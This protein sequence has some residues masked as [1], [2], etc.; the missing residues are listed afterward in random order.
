MTRGESAQD[1]MLC[2]HHT[3][4]LLC[5]HAEG[6]PAD[7]A[8]AARDRG[9]DAIGISDHNPM[10]RAFD[11]WRMSHDDLPRYLDLVEEARAAVDPFPVRLGLECDYLPGSESWIDT[12]ASRA[13]WDY[14][15]GA[16]HYIETDWDIDNPRWENRWRERDVGE[17]WG[18]YWSRLEQ[19]IRSGLF[20]IIAH[21]DLPK[22]FGLRPAGD[23]R[24]YYEPAIMAAAEMDVAFEINTAGLYKPCAE[25]YPHPIFLSLAREAGVP[26][27]ISSDAHAPAHVG[28]DF[29]VALEAA[30]RAGCATVCWFENRRRHLTLLTTPQR[31]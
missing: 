22:K 25:L 30:L 4:T 18:L 26:I 15:I 28:R 23:L 1:L 29:N 24:R 13:P 6:V 2:D 11:D 20:D 21:A 27:V 9:L 7:Y 14:L 17:I 5:G 3:H 10:P 8:R 12:L 31:K 16:V 19:C